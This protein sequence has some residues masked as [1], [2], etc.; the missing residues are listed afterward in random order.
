L[1]RAHNIPFTEIDITR[2]REAAARVRSW[3]NG[4]ETT[5][6]FEVNGEVVVNFQRSRLMELLGIQE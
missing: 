4:S 6:T 5:P 2:D 3:A 1:L